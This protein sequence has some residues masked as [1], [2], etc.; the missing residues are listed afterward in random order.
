MKRFS[1]TLV[2]GLLSAA[3]WAA[4]PETGR[5]NPDET[6]D[7]NL[8]NV[9]I[10]NGNLTLGINLAGSSIGNKVAQIGKPAVSNVPTIPTT[11]T[12]STT[13]GNTNTKDKQ[14]ASN[15][16]QI[17][18]M[19]GHH[20]GEHHEHHDRDHGRRPWDTRGHEHAGSMIGSLHHHHHEHHFA[21][22]GD[23]RKFEGM[24]GMK[25]PASGNAKL[26]QG[27]NKGSTQGSQLNKGNTKNLTKAT[28]TPHVGAQVHHALNTAAM[29]ATSHTP[30]PHA[31]KIGKK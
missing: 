23:H 29:H 5:A 18:Q 19:I 26:S 24:A 6:I 22:N 1:T 14:G 16:G 20:G 31:G 25:Q 9:R 4:L 15:L 11:N 30:A 17:G 3:L 7:V 12:T 8:N 21:F 2:V 28:Q 10:N 27:G 13:K